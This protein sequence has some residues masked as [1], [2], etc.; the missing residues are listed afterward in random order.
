MG[1]NRTIWCEMKQRITKS[2]FRE[3]NRQEEEEKK[4]KKHS[5]RSKFYELPRLTI[6]SFS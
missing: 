2:F 6:M 5:E 3:E 4:E 1:R